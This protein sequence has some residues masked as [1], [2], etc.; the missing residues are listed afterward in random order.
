MYGL[1]L[2]ATVAMC[3]ARMAQAEDVMAQHGERR[4]PGALVDRP[5]APRA[6]QGTRMRIGNWGAGMAALVWQD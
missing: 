2:L 4:E 1:A 6:Q 5:H 3:I